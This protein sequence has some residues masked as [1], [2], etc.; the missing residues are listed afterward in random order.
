MISHSPSV[1]FIKKL[2]CL[3]R[4]NDKSELLSVT[5]NLKEKAWPEFHNTTI[6]L[7][8]VKHCMVTMNLATFR[9]IRGKKQ[10]WTEGSRK[11][12]EKDKRRFFREIKI[13]Q[14]ASIFDVLTKFSLG[15]IMP[16]SP[17]PLSLVTHFHRKLAHLRS[18]MQLPF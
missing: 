12:G 8:V 17:P 2:L 11:E 5:T 16:I 7:M 6:F 4:N 15:I 3:S 1:M 14:K 13:G 9:Q 18:H 10:K